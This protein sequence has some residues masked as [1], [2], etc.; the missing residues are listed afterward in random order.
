MKVKHLLLTRFN[1]GVYD[2]YDSCMAAE[3][4][5]HRMSLFQAFTLPSVLAQTNQDFHWLLFVDQRTDASQIEIL[6][7]IPRATVVRIAPKT[8]SALLAPR[9]LLEVG[10]DFDYLLTSR[11]D[12]DDCIHSKFMEHVREAVRARGVEKRCLCFEYGWKLNL[13]TNIAAKVWYPANAFISLIEL[14][15]GAQTVWSGPHNRMKKQ[16]KYDRIRVGGMWTIVVHSRNIGNKINS[17]EEG[18]TKMWSELAS[19][20]GCNDVRV[21]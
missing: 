16:L 3:W 7:C 2:R 13:K 9:I 12:S 5:V 11:L 17:S 18:E 19:E 1:Y 10:D 20:F 6:K 15:K 14:R 8:A 4:T 21:S